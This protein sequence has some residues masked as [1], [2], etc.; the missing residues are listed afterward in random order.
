MG[1]ELTSLGGVRVPSTSNRQ[2]TFLSGEKPC[3]FSMSSA[4]S[5]FLSRNV[6][7]KCYCKVH[8]RVKRRIKISNLHNGE[9]NASAIS[10]SAKTNKIKY[11]MNFQL[12]K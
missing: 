8:S 10:C 6:Q 5:L 2:R 12:Y 4:P 7:Q 11:K 1:S 9:K 3:A